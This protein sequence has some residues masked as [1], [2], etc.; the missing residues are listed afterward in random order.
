MSRYCLTRAQRHSEGRRGGRPHDIV[1]PR[2]AVGREQ[3][4]VVGIAPQR[5]DKGGQFLLPR[6]L[7]ER[8]YRSGLPM[9]PVG[10]HFR[11]LIVVL[12]HQESDRGFGGPFRA[13]PR[14][15]PQRAPGLQR[16]Q[17]EG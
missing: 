10:K 4:Q 9:K 1:E 3:D 7:C 5:R 2:S 8:I 11:K 17:S 6:D 13:R 16:Y 15:T 14:R 12:S